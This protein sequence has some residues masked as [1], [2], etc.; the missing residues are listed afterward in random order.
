MPH[1]VVEYSAAG[2][3]GF[4]VAALLQSLHDAA[5]STGLMQAADIKVRALSYADYLVAGQRDGF[6]HVSVYL[7]EGRTP[8]QKLALSETLRAAMAALLPKTRSL[9]VDIRDMDASAY[10]K[11]LN[12]DLP[13]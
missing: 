7:L 2:H 5:A 9:S 3:A 6:C 12:P 4:D 1:I 10:K 11:R 13:R 8:A